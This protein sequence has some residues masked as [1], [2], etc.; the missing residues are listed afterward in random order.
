M[1]VLF[2]EIIKL[3]YEEFC[4]LAHE[5]F[6]LKFNSNKPNFLQVF[7]NFIKTSFWGQSMVGV[8]KNIV[9]FLFNTPFH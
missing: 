9:S 3:H 2:C 7:T 6:F 8:P 5:F 1:H 4:E